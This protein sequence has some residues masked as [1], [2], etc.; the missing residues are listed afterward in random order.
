MSKTTPTV[1]TADWHLPTNARY[2]GSHA[3]DET[4]DV[5]LVLRRRSPLGTL[6]PSA[7]RSER[8]ADFV[9]RYG[10]D[11]ADVERLRSFSRQHGLQELACE[12]GRRTLHLRGTA[13]SLQQA[14]GVQ[15]GHY[16]LTP[17]GAPYVGSAQAPVLPDPAVIAVLGLDQRPV[18]QPHF[19]IAQATPANTYTPLQ[20]GQ[21]YNFPAGDGTG[22]TIAIIELGGGYV[23]TD[24]DTYFKGLGLTTP[25]ITA[26]SVDGGSNQPG[27]DADAEVMLDI[28]VSGALAPAA[29]LVVYF[30]GNTDQGFYNAISQAAHSTTQPANVMSISWGG[31]E[32]NWSTASR[33][34]METALEDAAALGVT[35]TVAAGDNGSSDGVS[36]GQPT[37]DFPASSPS[38]LACGGT[39]LVGSGSTIKSEV[40][41]NETAGN[42]G[43]TGGGVSTVFALPSWQSTSKVPAAPNGFVGRGV[44]DV[45]GNAD[46]LTG[47]SVLVDGQSEVIGGTSAVAPLWAALVAR[48]NQQ[49]D[50]ALGA[51]N[52]ALYGI[53]EAPFHDITQGNN[54]SYAAGPGWDACTGLG[55]PNGQALL[56]ALQGNKSSSPAPAPSGHKPKGDTH[57]SPA[58]GGKPKGKA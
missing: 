33:N 56:S 50:H 39:E 37:V 7:S 23:Q 25:S 22:Q 6:A 55:S 4:L 40:V 46:P 8:H 30:A 18:A 31:P 26:V 29:Q 9:A 27:G 43:A 24:L 48:L 57:K 15:L 2:M 36:S 44:P 45:A 58:S 53:G 47:Y 12:P 11:P 14:F 32:S 54:G 51:A 1:A 52:A 35:V 20:V 28:E 41:W 3:P 13:Q 16:E 38:V 10:A 17:G 42:E 5:T 19:R 49:L 34:A 21:L